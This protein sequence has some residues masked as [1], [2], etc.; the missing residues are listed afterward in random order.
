MT[1]RALL[2]ISSRETVC[3]GLG[4]ILGFLLIV[5]LLI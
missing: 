4:I 2:E 5:N 3:F 1:F